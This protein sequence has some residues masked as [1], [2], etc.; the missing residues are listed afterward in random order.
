M[1]QQDNNLQ[2]FARANL[3]DMLFLD[4]E[5]TGFGADAE[6]LSY[7]II[8]PIAHGGANNV[9]SLVKPA[10]TDRWDRAEQINGISPDHVADKET[11]DCH[12]RSIR[13]LIRGKVVVAWNMPFDQ[14]F[15]HDKLKPATEVICLMRAYKEL[16]VRTKFTKL[17]VAADELSVNVPQGVAHNAK[18]DAEL[19]HNIAVV[20]KTHKA[21]INPIKTQ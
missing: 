14:A 9:Y 7:A 18:F 11:L 20:M 2:A 17:I 12:M 8:H 4:T 16:K 19:L 15:F 10:Y 5:T 1:A 6:M 3:D 21:V 13:K